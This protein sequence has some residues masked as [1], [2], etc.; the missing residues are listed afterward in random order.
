MLENKMAFCCAYRMYRDLEKQGVVPP[1]SDVGP[2]PTVVMPKA[3]DPDEQSAIEEVVAAFGTSLETSMKGTV[4]DPAVVTTGST[5]GAP[6]HPDAAISSPASSL[7][8]ASS[9]G[10]VQVPTPGSMLPPTS[11][12]DLV[13]ICEISIRRVIAMAKRISSFKRL[14]QQ[15]QMNLLKSG[16]IELLILRGVVGFDREKGVFLD[17]CDKQEVAISA[18]SVYE[19]EQGSLMRRFSESHYRFVRSMTVKLNADQTTLLLLLVITMLA[20]DRCP[21]IERA[22]IEQEQLRYTMLLK[23]YLESKY[24]L[25]LARSLFPKL[26][27]KLV[28]LRELNEVSLVNLLSFLFTFHF[29]YLLLFF[30]LFTCLHS[31]VIFKESSYLDILN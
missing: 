20:P 12:S 15:D 6:N 11:L 30:F 25:P 22:Y 2:A 21:L 28:E 8:D 4:R 5:N 3:L 27:A 23:R 29:V 17:P 1:K 24:P 7:S 31:L 19:V 16:S 26:L 13:N 9:P 14:P 18:Q 10:S